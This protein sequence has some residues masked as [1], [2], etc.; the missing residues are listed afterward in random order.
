MCS[1]DDDTPTGDHDPAIY[2]Q[3]QTTA[4][5]NIERQRAYQISSDQFS[6]VISSV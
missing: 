5:D 1:M 6:Q 2:T 3:L 4:E